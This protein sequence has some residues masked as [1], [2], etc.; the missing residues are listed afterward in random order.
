MAAVSLSPK[1]QVV[2]PKDVRRAL[3]LVAGQKLE[4][5]LVDGHVELR[6]EKNVRDLRGRWPGMDTTV[7]REPDRV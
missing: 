7:V 2:I 5:R 1:F 6:P 3:H 4:V